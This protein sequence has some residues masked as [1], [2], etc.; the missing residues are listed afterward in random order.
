MATCHALLTVLLWV[1]SLPTHN[2]V[3]QCPYRGGLE[4]STSGNASAKLNY[5]E[6]Q[7]EI[8]M[9]SQKV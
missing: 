4:V 7:T 6:R 8:T 1:I 9:F 2:M 5:K 3:A